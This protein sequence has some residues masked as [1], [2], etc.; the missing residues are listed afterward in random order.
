[1]SASI[2]A[3]AKR[4]AG[5][6]GRRVVVLVRGEKPVARRW[7]AT[8]FINMVSAM[9]I[10]GVLLAEVVFSSFRISIAPDLKCIEG[11][12]FFV[13]QLGVNELR[14]G[15]L[16]AFSA[17]GFGEAQGLGFKAG[18]VMG[19]QAVGLPGDTV[20][21]SGE[22]IT[23]NGEWVGGINPT[24]LEKLNLSVD[25]ITRSYVIPEGQVLMLG[26]LPRSVDG[27]YLG[28]VEQRLLVGRMWRLL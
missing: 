20:D 5:S 13:S 28:P 7:S 15:E 4:V 18:D 24:T 16:Y 3:S 17:V 8:Y 1:M 27:R 11:E 14:R 12:V 25:D 9:V 6:V 23:V 10:V 22:G 26:T 2:A 19:K 21:V